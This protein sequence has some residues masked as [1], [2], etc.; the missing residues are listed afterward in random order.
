MVL[1]GKDLSGK[2]AIVTGGG[3]GIG[4][5]IA[6][7]LAEA[8]AQV[9]ITGRRKEVLDE[10]AG[11]GL[12]AVQMDVADEASVVEGFA[13]AVD[14]RGPIS[15]CVPNAGLATGKALNK[16]D[17]DFWRMIIGVN[18]DGAFLTVR[19]AMKSM[20]GLDYGRV[21]A[22]S[23][24]A[25]LRGLRGAPA[26]S[27]SKHG[28]IGLMRALSEDYAGSPI[29]FNSLCPGYTDTEIITRNT[30]SISARAGISEEQALAMMVKTNKHQRL[31][32]VSEVAQ[33]AMWLCSDAACSVN[34]QNIEIAGGQM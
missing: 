22:V 17:M 24:I 29:T 19:E 27:A 13:S 25:G 14:A 8:G 6:Q 11:N 10:V 34:G 21:I 33:A 4:L 9:T 30:A 20:H 28:M 5:G 18:L 16:M 26:Y 3:T 2:H 15:I 31:V 12:H 32:A 23:S 7:A 1:A